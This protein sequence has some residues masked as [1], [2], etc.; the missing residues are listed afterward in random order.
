MA[1]DA[2]AEL[3]KFR[4]DWKKEVKARFKTSNTTKEESEL[5][6]AS[7][8]PSKDLST[9]AGR[10]REASIVKDNDRKTHET[11]DLLEP[12]DAARSED[13]GHEVI[14]NDLSQE[15][16]PRSALEHYERAVEREGEGSLGDSLKHYRTAYRL[17]SGVDRLYK[18]KHFPAPSKPADLNPSNA[19][20][21]VPN[22]AHHSL[23]GSNPLPVIDTIALYQTA[24]ICGQDS[25]TGTSTEPLCPIASLP[26]EILV[27]IL[28]NIAHFDI[29]IFA[30]VAQVC[31]RLAYLVTTEDRIWRQVCEGQD[32]GFGAMHYEWA[33]SVTGKSLPM[34][35]AGLDAQLSR[36]SLDP[37]TPSLQLSSEYPSF[38]S[39][40]RE[41][42]R[43]RFNGCY[44]STVNY[45]RPGAA[46]AS[47][48][49]F[50]SPV[51]IVT[52]YRYLR[53]FRDGSCVSLLTTTEPAEVVHHLTKEN[54]HSH[55]AGG[56]PSAVMNQAL[57]G[58]WKLKGNP[59]AVG[60]TLGEEGTLDIE[61]QG[62]DADRPQPKYI[63]KIML[64]LRRASKNP[65]ATRN[66]RLDWLGFWSY[67][68]LTDDWAEFNLKNDRAFFWSRVKSFGNGE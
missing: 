2:S 4:L 3:E 60:K 61:T 41:R 59:F 17:D 44:I 39:M 68:T 53:F 32:Y 6:H 20:A 38:R 31:K 43:I 29:A 13:G 34:S 65:K 64:Q 25:A 30:R 1:A 12:K 26:S 63:Y 14:P 22:T 42:P 15:A 10:P 40:F 67:N 5:G 23:E 46:T 58:R 50:S 45:I 9:P 51:L 57:R 56:L 37:V 36:A 52:Y 28:S 49:T 8:P 47:Q 54:I 24:S 16:E 62:A 19:P 18:N 33:L 27:T 35:I 66:N 21:T 11:R 55:H 48:A 7:V